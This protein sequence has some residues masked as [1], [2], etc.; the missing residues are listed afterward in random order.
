VI[1][2]V[3]DSPQIGSPILQLLTPEVSLKKD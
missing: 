1:S 2:Q 3:N